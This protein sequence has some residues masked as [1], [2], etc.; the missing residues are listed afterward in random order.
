MKYT[1]N[2]GTETEAEIVVIEKI[3]RIPS[4]RIQETVLVNK[5]STDTY[6]V[7]A[8]FENFEG[9]EYIVDLILEQLTPNYDINT[10]N[11]IKNVCFDIIALLRVNHDILPYVLAILVYNYQHCRYLLYEEF[12]VDY[13]EWLS[14]EGN[15]Y[16]E[17][18]ALTL[19]AI[20]HL[21][22]DDACEHCNFNINEQLDE[23]AINL[24]SYDDLL[25]P[26]MRRLQIMNSVYQ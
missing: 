21:L 10:S 12:E 22:C 6:R 7:T 23:R 3:R 20:E 8:E 26:T 2:K 25:N 11:I 19:K 1:V 13:V 24:K 14:I 17:D 4:G 16:I 18:D 5:E 15:D 9:K